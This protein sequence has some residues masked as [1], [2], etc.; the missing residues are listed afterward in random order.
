MP[1]A[2]G[3]EA[4]ERHDAGSGWGE[5]FAALPLESPDAGGWQRVQAHMHAPARSPARWPL[6]LATAASLAVAVAVPLRMQSTRVAD[7]PVP[8]RQLAS[9]ASVPAP[10]VDTAMPDAVAPVAIADVPAASMR[11]SGN[12]S[13]RRSVR[14]APSQRPIRTAAEPAGATRLAT[15]TGPAADDLEPLYARSAQL[16]SLL[17]LARDD[18]VASG[19]NAALSNDLDARVVAIDATLLQPGL[20]DAQRSDLW[21][22]RVDALQQLVGIETTNRLYAAR[23]ESYAAALVSID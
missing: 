5:A 15:N 14:I 19:T 8:A 10:S 22:Q 4:N 6:W 2:G 23:G 1:D 11:V 9:A 20:S 3:F 16:E 21:S 12:A 18:R 7:A 17:A 13:P